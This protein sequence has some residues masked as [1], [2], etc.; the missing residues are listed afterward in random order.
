MDDPSDLAMLTPPHFLIG[1]PL[2]T[3]SEPSVL[4]IVSN[5]LSHWQT[6]RKLYEEFW[7]KWSTNYLQEL[8]KRSKW[9]SS[10]AE[11]KVGDVCKL[12]SDSQPPCK[13][14]LARVIVIHSGPDGHARVVMLK[15]STSTMKRPVTKLCILPFVVNNSSLADEGGRNHVTD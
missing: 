4:K 13:W 11:V 7:K 5:R 1:E 3:I 12:R 14:P 15:T 9:K 8:Q 10:K 2:T 6:I